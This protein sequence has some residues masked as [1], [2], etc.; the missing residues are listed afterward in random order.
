MGDKEIN[1]NKDEKQKLKEKIQKLEEEPDIKN[2]NNKDEKK[3]IEENI[4]N[5][6]EEPDIK[7]TNNKDE[8]K[9]IEEN[10][11][12]IGE[13]PET[14]CT[15]LGTKKGC[16]ISDGGCQFCGTCRWK[17]EAE[18]CNKANERK[19]RNTITK[20]TLREILKQMGA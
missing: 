15:Q 1:N 10:I 19:G 11:K 14:V 2:T 16:K 20:K 7:N 6:G 17:K 8:K 18:K 9:E 4:K 12:N 13:E 3:E 5:I